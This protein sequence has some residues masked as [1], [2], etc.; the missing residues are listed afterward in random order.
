MTRRIFMVGGLG[1]IG[2]LAWLDAQEPKSCR[3]IIQWHSNITLEEA[4]KE[5]EKYSLKVQ[6]VYRLLS[7]KK[8]TLILAT[9]GPCR[10]NLYKDLLD[11][12]KILRVEEDHRKTIYPPQE[13]NDSIHGAPGELSTMLLLPPLFVGKYLLKT[14]K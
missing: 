3:F 4:K 10:T 1:Y 14:R 12:K 5:L 8:G 9:Q 11:N 13:K 6:S 7:Q 2:T